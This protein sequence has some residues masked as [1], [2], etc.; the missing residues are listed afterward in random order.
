MIIQASTANKT[1]VF[2]ISCRDFVSLFRS[3]SFMSF[4]LLPVTNKTN[5]NVKLDAHGKFRNTEPK[6]QEKWILSKLSRLKYLIKLISNIIVDT[7]LY[8]RSHNVI[9]SGTT[10][11]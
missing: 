2:L 10:M 8:I 3:N 5:Y 4:V 11:F 7:N 1:L 9:K 6:S